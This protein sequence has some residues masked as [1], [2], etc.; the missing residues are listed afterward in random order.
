[1]V[2]PDC[3]LVVTTFSRHSWLLQR[4]AT[5]VTSIVTFVDEEYPVNS[6]HAEFMPPTPSRRETRQSKKR[7]PPLGSGCLGWLGRS[8]SQRA[9]THRFARDNRG[10]PGQ[11]C[12]RSPAAVGNLLVD[13]S[14][15]RHQDRELMR[16]GSQRE[17]KSRQPLLSL[18]WSQRHKLVR[19][20]RKAHDF[21]IWKFC[22]RGADSAHH[23]GCGGC[24]RQS[25]PHG[26]LH[27]LKWPS[28]ASQ[29]NLLP[30]R[31]GPVGVSV[32]NSQNPRT[33]R[34]FCTP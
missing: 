13:Y 1:M 20:D 9:L 33:G 26:D 34:V 29:A 5:R 22:S 18:G 8:A 4:I 24:D 23:E 10:E 15:A 6:A 25:I 19:R 12:S 28:V 3:S 32:I 30:R 7:K 2:M 16:R 21:I 31:N 17:G 14:L 27:S 11:P